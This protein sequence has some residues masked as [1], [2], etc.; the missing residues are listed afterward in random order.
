MDGERLFCDVA[1]AER[2]ERA[3]ARWVA[4]CSDAARAR[5]GDTVGFARPLAGGIASFAEADSPFDKVAGLGF[6][7]VPDADALDEVERAF[8]EL[9]A[10]VQIELC[11]LADPEVGAFLTDRGYRLE[12][13]ENVLG[14]RLGDAVDEVSG[15]VRPCRD[16]ELETWL[17]AV[18]DASL[19]VDTE[20]LP[21]HEDFSR[22]TLVTVLRDMA[23]VRR[24]LA[25]RDGEFAGGASF[26]V[27]DGIAQFAGAATVPAHR[28]RGVQT[29]LLRARLAAARAAGCDLAIVTTLL[30]TK[31]Q[32]NAQRQGF[33][34]LYARAI[35]VKGT[36]ATRSSGAES[37]Q[38]S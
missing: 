26:R 6:E 4:D 14:R 28:R 18:A 23:G 30:G 22:E 5:R 33:D 19:V 7:G 17:A 8:A 20:G 38:A 32:Q 9:G 36:S 12:S 2:I 29:A 15:D 27:T 16:D 31:S 24:F 21:S 11:Q 1:L 3:E 35:L 13:Y 37:R 10:P 25:E 34:L